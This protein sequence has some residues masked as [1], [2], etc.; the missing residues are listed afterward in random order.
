[1]IWTA[2]YS[3]VEDDVEEDGPTFL[4]DPTFEA[5]SSSKRSGNGITINPPS[6]KAKHKTRAK[7]K[8]EAA[9]SERL[10][11]EAELAAAE[12]EAHLSD[13]TDA[14]A[15][16]PDSNNGAGPSS[17]SPAGAT[18]SER[19]LPAHG[20]VPQK[21]QQLSTAAEKKRRKKA[22]ANAARSSQEAAVMQ[23]TSPE[24]ES[25]DLI[26]G[27][28]GE[29][30]NSIGKRIFEGL[31][32][33]PDESSD[34]PSDESPDGSPAVSSAA[35][36]ATAEASTSGRES[37]APKVGASSKKSKSSSKHA[38][39]VSSEAYLE[40]LQAAA[41]PSG[42]LVYQNGWVTR[43][44]DPAG[45]QS[46]KGAPG[47]RAKGFGSPKDPPKAAS[48]QLPKHLKEV[49]AAAKP[50]GP[51]AEGAETNSTAAGRKSEGAVGHLREQ[52]DPAI[53]QARIKQITAVTSMG[54]KG[55]MVLES[56]D[57]PAADTSTTGAAAKK[58]LRKMG[59]L[60]RFRRRLRR[61]WKWATAPITSAVEATWLQVPSFSLSLL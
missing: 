42:Q 6:R 39:T 2:V 44:D 23:D 11:H 21:Q 3:D 49:P 9:A 45:E 37:S 27:H 54:M 60:R 51:A 34:G 13:E 61:G 16:I 32:E 53:S 7:A 4:E 19:D 41:P 26:G 15:T 12:A 46:V 55:P 48:K 20:G 38:D 14:G 43:E 58:A 28:V 57:I 52:S 31:D 5:G 40:G 59:P 25:G 24:E 33:S 22:A 35:R 10:Q 30:I 50:A 29:V 1:M 47:A 18:S 56:V 36:D 8:Q 17:S